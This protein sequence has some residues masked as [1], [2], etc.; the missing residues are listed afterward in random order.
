MVARCSF[1]WADSPSPSEMAERARAI[2][3]AATRAF[4]ETR[5]AE[6]AQKFD[7]AASVVPSAVAFFTGGLAWERAGDPARAADDYA[8]ALELGS[9]Q[10]G[11]IDEKQS[12]KAKERLGALEATFGTVRVLGPS[13][14]WVRIE[15]QGV[16]ARAPATLH[17]AAG[18]HYVVARS[19]PGEPPAPS[20]SERSFV[21]LSVGKTVTLDLTAKK[22]DETA[23]RGVPAITS[24]PEVAMVES[25]TDAEQSH[26]LATVGCVMMGVGAAAELAAAIVWWGP[27]MAARD[28]YRFH[29]GTRE[30]AVGFETLT[31]V[32]LIG[33]AA[34]VGVGTAFTI[35]GRAHSAPKG[36]ARPSL[37]L[38]VGLGGAALA[39]EW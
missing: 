34:L 15:D 2:Y 21:M 9:H 16:G 18:G 22:L 30:R 13:G 39:G 11:G 29:T 27:A 4:A 17:A 24:P 12:D 19:L 28:D 23:G 10:P 36:T 37:G 33:G 3:A 26:G 1:A 35:I 25:P 8:R 20:A 5:F 32:A 6:A 14:T 31:N 38:Q 7:E